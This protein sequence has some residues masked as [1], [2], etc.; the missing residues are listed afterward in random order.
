MSLVA[1]TQAQGELGLIDRLAGR[2]LFRSLVKA[3]T[4]N[5]PL[6]TYADVPGEQS[7][8]RSLVQAIAFDEVFREGTLI[9]VDAV[10]RAPEFMM[11]KQLIAERAQVDPAKLGDE[12]VAMKEV[13]L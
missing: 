6:G 2:Q 12:Q 7:L 9:A 1:V 10:N 4:L 11:S 5:H 8:Q 13:R 3:V